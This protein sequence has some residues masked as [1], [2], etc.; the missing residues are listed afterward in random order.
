MNLKGFC[1]SEETQQGHKV[2]LDLLPVDEA[3]KRDIRYQPKMVNSMILLLI[4][5]NGWFE[6]KGCT[7]VVFDA[8]QNMGEI[9][10]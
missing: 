7:A 4:L 10:S 3:Q 8:E 9:Q 6:A 1:L 2:L 5:R